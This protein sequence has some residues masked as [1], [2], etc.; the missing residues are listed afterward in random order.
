MDWNN[1]LSAAAVLLVIYG[2][3]RLAL[4]LVR[5]FVTIRFDP[6][7]SPP[8]PVKKSSPAKDWRNPANAP[9]AFPNISAHAF[10]PA[11]TLPCCSLCGGGELHEVHSENYVPPPASVEVVGESPAEKVSRIMEK[12]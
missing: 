11:E 6:L 12:G 2:V 7:E 10:Q 9:P 5:R 8:L 1:F 4:G 3:A